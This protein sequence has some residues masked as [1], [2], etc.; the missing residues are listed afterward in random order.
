MILPLLQQLQRH[1]NWPET[2]TSRE[3]TP[4]SPE[5]L[6]PLST[7][8]EQVLGRGHRIRCCSGDVKAASG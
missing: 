5:R 6:A 1:T 8:C 3:G 2:V 4:I 7:N